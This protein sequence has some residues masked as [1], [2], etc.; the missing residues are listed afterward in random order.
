MIHLI[1]E[2]ELQQINVK[3][4][5][6][7]DLLSTAHTYIRISMNCTYTYVHVSQCVGGITSK[8]P[9]TV[10]TLYTGCIFDLITDIPRF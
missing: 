10:Y 2:S 3:S 6:I 1:F 9:T 4:L 7:M 5:Y 8:T